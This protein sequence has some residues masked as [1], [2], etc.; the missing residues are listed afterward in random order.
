MTK[1]DADFPALLQAFFTDRLMRQRQTSSH[2]IASYRDTFR[3]LFSFV[4]HRV[5]KR[6]PR[7]LDEL[8]APFLG[9]FLDHLE[10]ERGNGA[11]SRNARPPHP[12]FLPLRGPP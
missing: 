4:E 3:L 2:S 5:K 8:D 7:R 10:Q 6:P 11:C 9:A 12:S 1:T